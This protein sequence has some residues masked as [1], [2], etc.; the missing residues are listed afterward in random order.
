VTEP[1]WNSDAGFTAIYQANL[2]LVY[3]Y[4]LRRCGSPHAAEELTAIV[5]VECWKGRHRLVGYRGVPIAWLLGIAA[6][7]LRNDRRST[8]RRARAVGRLHHDLIVG[9]PAD[10]VVSRTGGSHAVLQVAAALALLSEPHRRVIEL[11]LA[12][13]LTPTE[14]AAQLELPVGTVKS[15]L[16]R[17]SARLRDSLQH[18]DPALEDGHA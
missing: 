11:C 3:A 12:D 16:F 10:D 15:R 4:C 9:D 2:S 18:L 13:G 1:D 6:N 8:E 5:F 14:A 17:G 7:L